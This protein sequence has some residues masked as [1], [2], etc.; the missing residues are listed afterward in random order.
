[1]G[2]GKNIPKTNIIRRHVVLQPLAGFQQKFTTFHHNTHNCLKAVNERV[3]YVWDKVKGCLRDP[4]RPSS[5]DV[6]DEVCAYFKEAICEELRSTA[7]YRMKLDEVPAH[8]TGRKRR[9]YE[10]AVRAIKLTGF[11]LKDSFIKA[12]I[13]HEKMEVYAKEFWKVVC[14]LISPRTAKY[15]AMLMRYL[16]PLEKKLYKAI[17]KV[18]NKFIGCSMTERTVAKGM[19]ARETAKHIE[20][21]FRRIPDCVVIGID[22]ERFDEHTSQ[23]ALIF[24]HDIYVEAFIDRKEKS[25]LRWLLDMQLVNVCRIFTW[26]HKIAYKIL[27]TRASGDANTGSGNT[28]ISCASVVSFAIKVGLK[29]WGFMNNGDDI[30]LFVSRSQLHLV[31][32]EAISEFW[33]QLGYSMAIEEPVHIMEDIEFCQCKP[34]YGPDGYIMIRKRSTMAK[35]AVFIK[36]TNQETSLKALVGAVG[37]CGLATASGIPVAQSFYNALIRLGAQVGQSKIRREMSRLR[38]E[39][40]GLGTQSKGLRSKVKEPSD[41]SR[42]SYMLQTGIPPVVQRE[43]EAYY[44]NISWDGFSIV[45]TDIVSRVHWAP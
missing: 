37:M 24:E 30:I 26:A 3:F 31:S 15:N 16:I 28:L 13:K 35:D 22:A 38:T 29:N 9:I 5:S 20:Q 11:R 27:G 4:I 12:F 32:N 7:G 25:T 2:R 6:F 40:W 44:D 41:R 10:E 39:H 45:D 14:R 8:H 21:K 1:M 23:E 36:Y 18:V 33:A 42:L 43:M 34:V 19:N 17:D